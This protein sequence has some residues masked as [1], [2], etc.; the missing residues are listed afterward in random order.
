[1]TSI[2]RQLGGGLLIVL[3]ATVVLVGQGAVWLFDRA[4]RDYLSSDLQ[5]EADALLA[6]LTPGPDGLY[7][8]SARL[9]GD[10]MRS[11]SGRYFV[12]QAGEDRWRSRSLWDQRLP[13]QSVEQPNAL[14][15]GPG[16][17]QLLVRSDRFQ[18]LG[19]AVNISVALDYQ[20]LLLAFERARNW[21]WGL[22][23]IAV[24]IS[25][26]IQQW[27]LR[28]AL[29]PL[30][31]ARQ[32]LAE[33]QAGERLILNDAVPTELLPLV[34]EINH[35]GAQI[36]Q[37][38]QRSRKGVGDLSHGLKTPLAVVESLLAREEFG[39]ADRPVIETQLREMRGQLERALQR[40]RLAPESHSGNRFHPAQDLPWLIGSL[41][42]IHGEQV[43]IVHPPLI[44]DQQWPFE[45]EDMLELLGNLL[46][47]A[48]KWAVSQVQ[49][50]WTVTPETVQ[51]RIQDD[52]PGIPE[53][54]RKQALMR[55]TRLD[56]S[57]TG[58]GLGLAIVGD[59]VEVYGGELTLE[60]SELGGLAVV[61]SLP[62]TRR[63]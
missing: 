4:L 46:D 44:P 34:R 28:R 47:N 38:I 52:G 27:L 40:A 48:C 15:P 36:D 42:Q 12:V 6:A 9:G 31:H 23:A 50:D 22:G 55:G 54:K 21:I 30:R 39:P 37:T 5:R 16:G 10:Y 33:W 45:R 7:L 11:F 51:L 53:Q 61:V 3:L 32:E 43:K 29:H 2:N 19:Q 1:M 49:L 25:L 24:L 59:L 26:L 35:L 8:D 62:V 13:S 20:P 18:K 58:H 17:Q 57:V 63:A 14:V 41:Q 56:E 60:K